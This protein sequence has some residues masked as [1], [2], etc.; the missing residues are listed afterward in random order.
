MKLKTSRYL[1]IYSIVGF[2]LLVSLGLICIFSQRLAQDMASIWVM[3]SG[4]PDYFHKVARIKPW[5]HRGGTL[6]LM[7]SVFILTLIIKYLWKSS[8]AQQRNCAVTK[9]D[10]DKK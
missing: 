3:L 8:P 6:S 4:Q 5:L 10:S 7:L 2:I 1:Q 9:P